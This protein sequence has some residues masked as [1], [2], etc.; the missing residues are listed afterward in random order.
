MAAI[1]KRIA[2]VTGTVIENRTSCR[3][4]A[5]TSLAA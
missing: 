5:E 4:Q 3:R 1:A 2:A